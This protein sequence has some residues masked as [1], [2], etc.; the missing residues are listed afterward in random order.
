MSEADRLAFN[1]PRKAGG[2]APPCAPPF[3]A[4]TKDMGGGRLEGSAPE[5]PPLADYRGPPLP[6][7]YGEPSS[8]CSF[9][10][11]GSR[12]LQRENTSPLGFSSFI[13]GI[14][15]GYMWH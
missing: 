8:G 6:R 3:P 4:L 11:D 2:S 1:F 9:G 10:P 5:L 15:W 12:H 13:V 7:V 14:S